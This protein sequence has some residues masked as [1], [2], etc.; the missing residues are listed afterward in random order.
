MRVEQ[1]MAIVQDLLNESSDDDDLP[2]PPSPKRQNSKG[3]H[4]RRGGWYPEARQN[5]TAVGKAKWNHDWSKGFIYRL[6]QRVEA[7]ASGYWDGMHRAR[8]G[9]PPCM[10]A[11]HRSSSRRRAVIRRSARR[12]SAMGRPKG[13]GPSPSTSRSPRCS[14]QCAQGARCRAPRIAPKSTWRRSGVSARHI[15]PRS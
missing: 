9:V 11:Q 14:R 12:R 2:P 15:S 8:L 13:R 6:L 1:A 3:W 4:L 7:E 10:L 5:P